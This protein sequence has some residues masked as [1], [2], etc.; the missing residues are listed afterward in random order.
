[1]GKKEVYNYCLNDIDELYDRENRRLYLYGEV[2]EETID[3]LV[4][5][6]MKFNREDKDKPIEDRKPIILYINSPGGSVSDGFSLI[7]YMLESK[8]EIITVNQGICY[9]MGFLIFLAGGKRYSMKSATFLCHEGESAAFG[10]LSK[11]KDRMEFE[12]GQ[13]EEYITNYIV[14]RTNISEELYKQ[15][16]RKEWYMYPEEA[17]EHGIVTHIV[18]VDCDMDEIL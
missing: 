14:T 3:G 4:Y 17:K 1:M 13:M 6:I 8:T 7:D 11:L 2:N 5:M 10:T 12:N 9:S 16:Y 15:Q 18:G